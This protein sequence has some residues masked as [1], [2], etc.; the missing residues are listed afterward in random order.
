M[1]KDEDKMRMSSLIE[2]REKY[3]ARTREREEEMRKKEKQ[4]TDWLVSLFHLEKERR[5]EKEKGERKAN[6]LFI[7]AKRD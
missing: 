6:E 1:K 7:E 4:F 3:R 5:K 2:F